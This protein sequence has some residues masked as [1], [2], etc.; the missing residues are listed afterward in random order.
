METTNEPAGYVMPSAMVNGL[1]ARWISMPCSEQ[2]VDHLR[3]GERI[4]L[5]AWR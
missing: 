2:L 5:Q 1:V 3:R 4:V